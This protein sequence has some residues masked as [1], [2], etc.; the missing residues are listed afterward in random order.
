MHDLAACPGAMD[1]AVPT[2]TPDDPSLSTRLAGPKSVT[3]GCPAPAPASALGRAVTRSV[4]RGRR[5]AQR[6]ARAAAGQMIS[7]MTLPSMNVSRS[8]RPRCG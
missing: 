6:S 1:R 5:G 4:K 3:N 8:S 7:R 2:I